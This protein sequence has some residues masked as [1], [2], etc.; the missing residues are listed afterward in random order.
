MMGKLGQLNNIVVRRYVKETDLAQVEALERSC[1]VGLGASLFAD[2]LGDPLCRVRHLPVHTMLVAEVAK[3]IV[4]VVRGGVN[5]VVCRSKKITGVSEE[6]AS[7]LTIVPVYARVGY[8]LGLRVCPLHRKMGIAVKLVE[9]MEEW[10]EEQQAEYVYIA[11]EKDN[12]ASVKLFT[13]RLQYVRFRSPVILVHPVFL[14][15]RPLP[16]DVRLTKL[17]VD[18]AASLYRATSMGTA[19]FFPKDIHSLL[20]NELCAG[21]WVATFADDNKQLH[22]GLG[23]VS[24]EGGRTGGNKAKMEATGGWAKGASWAV[25]SIWRSNEVFKFEMRGASWPIRTLATASRW[26]EWLLPWFPIPSIPNLF[27]SSFGFQFMFGLHSEGPRGLEL[28][29]SLCWH[30]HNVA[31]KH[32]CQA[33]ATE[34]AASDPAT[35]CIPHWKRLSSCDDLWC[36]KRLGTVSGTILSELTEPDFDNYTVFD[37]CTSPQQS[38]LFV[39]PREV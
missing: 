18:G 20:G 15:D 25:L 39:D 9:K 16:P 37:W 1:E 32:G 28:L 17:S 5:D 12:V 19:E 29:N 30:A 6:D 33:L 24:H 3:Q 11:T 7:S 8:L 14:R 31:R 38:K 27:T 13:E 36:M 21:T 35:V 10:C 23:T 2:M 34:L 26:L 4:G 22:A